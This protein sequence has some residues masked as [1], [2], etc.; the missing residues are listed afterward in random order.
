M[1]TNSIRISLSFVTASITRS[2]LPTQP[3]PA[4]SGR[5]Y[6]TLRRTRGAPS[7]SERTRGMSSGKWKY[8]WV[9]PKQRTNHWHRWTTV[10]DTL[11]NAIVLPSHVDCKTKHRTKS[12]VS[13]TS[14]NVNILLFLRRRV[15]HK[16][17]HTAG[18]WLPRKEVVPDINKPGL[19]TPKLGCARRATSGGWRVA[20]RSWENE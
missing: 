18:P 10:D 17:R 15:Q 7:S 2:H 20:Y 8:A 14:K 6:S 3:A 11:E 1:P 9:Y 16:T 19:L 5:K 12:S 13:C 4:A